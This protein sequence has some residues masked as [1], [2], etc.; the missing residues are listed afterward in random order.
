MDPVFGAAVAGVAGDLAS[1]LLNQNFSAKQAKQQMEFQER[2]SN[3]QYQRAAADLEKAGLNRVLALGSPASSPSGAMGSA[4]MPNLGSSASS[5]ASAAASRSL[6]IE[7]AKA[8]KAQNDMIP[9]I[10]EKT[11]QEA[12]MAMSNALSAKYDAELKELEV[13]KQ[14]ILKG[15][16]DRAGPAANEFL[17]QVPGFINSVKDVVSDVPQ[18]VKTFPDFVKRKAE[19]VGNSAKAIAKE[20]AEAAAWDAKHAVRAARYLQPLG[21]INAGADYLRNKFFG[22]KKK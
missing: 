8:A 17:D 19:T 9:D 16:Y 12:N 15:I 20:T 3:T 10:Q 2:M 1:G 22:G 5:A 11:H 21:P 18:A 4:T 6:V 14:R 13:A 7:Q